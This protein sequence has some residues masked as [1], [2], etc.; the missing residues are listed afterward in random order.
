MQLAR[1]RTLGQHIQPLWDRLGVFPQ[2][3]QAFF[4]KNSAISQRC[5]DACE[6]ELARL[7]ELKRARM[8]D[9]VNAARATLRTRLDET[10][11][12]TLERAKVAAL[13]SEAVPDDVAA[14][15]GLLTAIETEVARLDGI[16]EQLQ[17]I[18]RACAK[19]LALAGERNE[20]EALIQDSTRLLNRKRGGPSMFEEEQ[21]RA[22]VTKDL[23][24]T[25]QTLTAAVAAY[26]RDVLGNA[27]L[28]M[29]DVFGVDKPVLEVLQRL[30]AEHEERVCREREQKKGRQEALDKKGPPTMPS[31][32][33]RVPLASVTVAKQHKN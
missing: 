15:E 22:R 11:T 29:A 7:T 27:P 9:F 24:R 13:L 8:A 6:T 16:L 2:E 32:R 20:Y 1:L 10:R 23:P 4:Q 33:P 17:P 25:L 3:Q 14:A 5:V 31:A 28:V 21:M 30:E 18:V 19:Y 26:Q 12:N